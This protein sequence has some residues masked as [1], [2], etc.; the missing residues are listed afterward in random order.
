MKF[1]SVAS[2]AL[3]LFITPALAQSPAPKPHNIIIF[4]ADGL[5]YGSVE[6]N[7]MPNM[8]KL[9]SEGVDFTNSHSL[10]PT[11]TTVNASAITTGHYIG[12][13]GNFGNTL[14]TATPVDTMK[15]EPIAA[16]ENDDVLAEMNKKFGGNY[17]NEE[18]LFARA[19]AQGFSTAV[20]GKLGP[21][22]I[23]DSTAAPD[24]S[25]T[26]ILDDN[27]G[28]PGGIGLP[29]WFTARMKAAFVEPQA[30]ATQVPNIPQEVYLMKATTR[31]VLPHFKQA[32]KPFAMLFWSRDPDASQHGTRDSLGEYEP[33]INGPS[34]KAGTRDADTALGELRAALKAQGLDATTDIFVTADH[35]FL[36]IS[37]ASDTSPSAVNGQ[38]KQGFLAADLAKGLG[39]SQ[40]G[41]MLGADPKNPEAIV[42]GNGGADL[43]YLP[44]KNAK[45]LAGSVVK[46]LTTQ[47]YVSAIFVHDSLGKI[48][49]ALPMSALNLIGSAK[50]P[51]PS[52]YVSF[53]SFAGDCE[54]KL[55]CAV[56]VHDTSLG[57]GQ[58]SHGSLSRAETRNFMAAVGPSF[59]SGFADPAPISNADITPT[60]AHVAGI[61]LA[62]KGK[63]TGRVISEALAGGGEVKPTQRTL[64]STPA[65]N[66]MRTILN[67]QE[68]GQARYFDAAGTLGKTV[69]LN[70]P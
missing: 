46:F 24:G 11:I 47:D 55:Q 31:I 25:E 1:V 53:R 62:P 51:V 37:H 22:R 45:K 33:G 54:N 61:T 17:L 34:G 64:Q 30:P 10:F 2:L 3:A 18:T 50:T 9:K 23:A 36:T 32:G 63:L 69:G 44:Q 68:V 6:P 67:L 58:G 5:R 65:A 39:L 66:G 28:H 60:L 49:G 14:Y 38:I 4:V 56:G 41:S 48:P 35:G 8:F 15:G 42:V 70:P 13:T 57:T 26:L 12:D 19:R 16:L 7:N 40:S 59:K 29:Q 21:T 43:I 27:T 52:I 20:I